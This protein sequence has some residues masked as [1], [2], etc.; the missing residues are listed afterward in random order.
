MEVR[1]PL[2]PRRPQVCIKYNGMDVI[3]DFAEMKYGNMTPEFEE[4]PDKYFA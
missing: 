4:H 1:V 2:S 3:I